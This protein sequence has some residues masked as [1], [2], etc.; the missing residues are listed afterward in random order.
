MEVSTWLEDTTRDILS[1]MDDIVISD[2]TSI[3]LDDAVVVSMITTCNAHFFYLGQLV[4]DG[5]VHLSYV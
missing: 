2:R 1:Y 4:L 5:C 3:T